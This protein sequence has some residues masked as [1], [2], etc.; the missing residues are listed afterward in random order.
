M[1]AGKCPG[2]SPVLSCFKTCN[3]K[4]TR[5]KLKGRSRGKYGPILDFYNAFRALLWRTLRHCKKFLQWLPRT[6]LIFLAPMC[7]Q[8]ARNKLQW[9][10]QQKITSYVSWPQSF[11]TVK[12]WEFPK[13]LLLCNIILARKLRQ[14]LFWKL[15]VNFQ[16]N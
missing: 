8:Q 2:T 9:S 12:K 11:G 15:K 1:Y 16:L 7:E 14:I 13:M 6:G 5:G 4:F 10:F 3:V